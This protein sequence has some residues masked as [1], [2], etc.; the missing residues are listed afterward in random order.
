[1][2][3]ISEEADYRS[4]V[5]EA[6]G[7]FDRPEGQGA[8]ENRHPE[9]LKMFKGHKGKVTRIE[10]NPNLKQLVTTGTDSIVHVWNYKKNARPYIFNTHKGAIYGLSVNPSGNLIATG[11]ADKTIRIWNNTMEGYS[12]VLKSHTGAVRDLSFSCDGQL[13][14]SCSDDKTLR[15]WNITENKYLATIAAHKNW[16]RTCHMSPDSTVLVSGSDDTTVKLWDSTTCQE[17]A[18]LTEHTG[19]INSV[20]FHPDGSCIASGAT[21]KTIK[22]WDA[23]IQRLLQHYDAHS[24]AVNSINFHPTGNYLISTSQDATIKIWDL[25]QGSILY[26]LYAHEGTTSAAAFSTYGSYFATGGQDTA[27]QVWKSNLDDLKGE[28]IEGLEDGAATATKI[29]DSQTADVPA[30]GEGEDQEDIRVIEGHPQ[31]IPYQGVKESKQPEEVAPEEKRTIDYEK[32]PADFRN[33]LDKMVFH[34]DLVS[35]TMGALEKRLNLSENK[36]SEVLE[37]FKNIDNEGNNRDIKSSAVIENSDVVKRMSPDRIKRVI[38]FND[39]QE[40]KVKV[41]PED[42]VDDEFMR[43]TNRFVTISK[44]KF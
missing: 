25:R 31:P 8:E 9:N 35:K 30:Y 21:D 44:R 23:R 34:L 14:L 41:R 19:M 10:F 6:T 40:A 13:L 43:E 16:V 42:D 4:S 18:K 32:V 5:Y 29:I 28:Y 26:T 12:K 27:V 1:M 22:I 7:A 38:D 39:K 33:T 2:N 37:Y 36:M 20:R 15:M 17:M 3:T 11:S 24:K